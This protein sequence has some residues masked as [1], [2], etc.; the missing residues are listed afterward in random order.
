MS[1][2]V[3]NL[4]KRLCPET[5]ADIVQAMNESGVPIRWEKP[6]LTYA[7]T[8]A[9]TLQGYQFWGDIYSLYER[10]SNV[11]VDIYTL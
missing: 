11:Y 5:V 6:S 3:N 7:F 10:R 9:E 1:L 8:W 4:R 2:L